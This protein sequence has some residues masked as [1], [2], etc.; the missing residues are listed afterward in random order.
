MP[1]PSDANDLVEVA[2]RPDQPRA[3][4]PPTSTDDDPL[5]GF[6]IPYYMIELV[7]IVIHKPVFSMNTSSLGL[8][9]KST[10]R[11]L[12]SSREERG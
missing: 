11:D 9:S 4:I 6:K 7:F 3:Q 10:G 5:K 12:K 1:K 8:R 2:T